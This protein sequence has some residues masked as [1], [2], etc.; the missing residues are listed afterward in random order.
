MRVQAREVIA[1]DGKDA[2]RLEDVAG[3]KGRA[4]SGLGLRR[5]GGA[6]ARPTGG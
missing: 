5:R 2:A 6:R 3:G 1:V 4:A